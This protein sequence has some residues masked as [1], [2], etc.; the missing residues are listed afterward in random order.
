MVSARPPRALNVIR[1]PDPEE[2]GVPID[3]SPW[4]LTDEEDMGEG[5]EQHLVIKLLLSSLDQLA[6][7]RGWQ[8]VYIGADQ[9]FAWVPAEP[10]VR[11]S[12]DVYLL[13]DPPE[14]PLPASWQTWQ[15]GHS[16]PRF[17]VE[18][19][20]GDARHPG[21]RKDYE[22]AP[23]KY[24]QLGARELVIFDPEA[25]AKRAREPERI[26]LQLYRREAD[27]SFVRVYRGSGPTYSAELAAHL[28]AVVNGPIARLRV[29][30]DPEGTDL[31]PTEA[32]ALEAAE[33]ELAKLRNDPA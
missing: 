1:D 9:F 16:P 31:V 29:A 15:D 5:N 2:L 6:R 18:V 11:V 12:P 3:W 28:V 24:A 25:A 7:E 8:R 14:P 32:E 13:D 26:P 19:V 22:E 20:S 23:Q 17:A 21:W 33:R 27:D 4:Y 30:R 10:L